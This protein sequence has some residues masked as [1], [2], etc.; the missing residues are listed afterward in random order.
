[1]S[2]AHETLR[3]DAELGEVRLIPPAAR[4]GYVPATD[5]PWLETLRLRHDALAERLARE[6]LVPGRLRQEHEAAVAAWHDS[7][8]AAARADSE[9]PA[10]SARLTGAW[11][12]GRVDRAE[13]A[14]S[15]T[16][17]ELI[18]VLNEADALCAEH[19][20]D[21]LIRSVDDGFGGAL[22]AKQRQLA[23]ETPLPAPPL[24]DLAV[25]RWRDQ[26]H[27][28]M[29]DLQSYIHRRDMRRPTMED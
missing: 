15:D 12:T 4:A 8:R 29:R 1:M 25:R 17:G 11:L 2:V 3:P 18:D 22:I 13:A 7:V 9:P 19:D 16:V 23:G 20:L 10:W 14:V 21:A 24:W 26:C 28:R 6:V 27:D 5:L